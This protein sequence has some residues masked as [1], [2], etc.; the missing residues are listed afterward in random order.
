MLD[1]V[2]RSTMIEDEIR[3]EYKH[4]QASSIIPAKQTPERFPVEG[5]LTLKS[6]GVFFREDFF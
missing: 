2:I 3:D 4:I 5:T 1:P 6:V